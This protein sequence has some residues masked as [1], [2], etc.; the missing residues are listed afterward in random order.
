MNQPNMSESHREA[1]VDVINMGANKASAALSKLIEKHVEISI[2]ELNLA[3]VEKI[4]EFLGDNEALMTVVLIRMNHDLEGTVMLLLPPD[5]ALKIIEMLTKTH[6]DDINLI[7]DFDKSALCEAGNI[8]T[9]ACTSALSEFLKLNI[10][11]TIPDV[12]TD[13]VGALLSAVLSDIGQSTDTIFEFKVNC[14]IDN[15]KIKGNLVFLFKPEATQKIFD[16]L[17]KRSK[18]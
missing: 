5:K 11:Q 2:P 16:I 3:S 4:P 18:A 8:L 6:K 17:D 7:D 13:M 14:N 1:L 9:G 15:E 12:A 10:M